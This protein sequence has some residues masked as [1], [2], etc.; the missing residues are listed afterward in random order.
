M[1]RSIQFV[2]DNQPVAHLYVI[3]KHWNHHYIIEEETLYSD[4]NGF[5]TFKQDSDIQICIDSRYIFKDFQ[6][7]EQND[8]MYLEIDFNRYHLLLDKLIYIVSK[9]QPIHTTSLDDIY[10]IYQKIMGIETYPIHHYFV[11][12]VINQMYL[13]LQEH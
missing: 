4:Q 9:Y 12:S 7:N 5:I 8:E 11:L 1:K 6:R 10:C 2:Y 3:V 13:E